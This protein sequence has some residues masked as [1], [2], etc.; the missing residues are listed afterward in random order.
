[1]DYLTKLKMREDIL[2][3]V[4]DKSEVTPEEVFEHLN[5][6]YTVKLADV[7][8]ILKELCHAPRLQEDNGKY[9]VAEDSVL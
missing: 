6:R 3:F 9:L 2:S 4:Q 1:M 7:K 8:T 5:K